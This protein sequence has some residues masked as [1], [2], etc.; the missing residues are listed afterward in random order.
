[1]RV[2]GG[3]STA[4]PEAAV[5]GGRIARAFHHLKIH[6]QSALVAYL[7]GGD[8]SPKMSLQ[9]L[10]ACVA[11]GADILEIGIP[12]S[13]PMAEGMSIQQG[14]A[15]AL[16]AGMTA[17]KLFDL[18]RSFRRN[19]EETPLVLM[20]YINSLL[21]MGIE[22]FVAA[23]AAAG[24]DGLLI[25]DMPPEEAGEVARAMVKHRLDLILLVAPNTPPAR[26]KKIIRA[27]SGYL[28]FM[29][30][31]G[32]TGTSSPDLA[33]VRERVPELKAEAHLPLAVGFGVRDAEAAAQLAEVADA[34]VVG[35]ALVEH[36]ST[37]PFQS[38]ILEQRVQELKSALKAGEKGA[39]R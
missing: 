39:K 28:Y 30:Y 10:Q 8:P 17:A 7:V 23:A 33:R 4:L 25:V 22:A 38:E 16:K 35:S 24:V 26:L 15:R 14:H 11:G 31:A 27:A 13:D 3:S 20:G 12:F 5:A 9:A 6:H 36:C 29:S 21:A 37:H 34:V 32:V 2:E 1:M 19:D 18:V